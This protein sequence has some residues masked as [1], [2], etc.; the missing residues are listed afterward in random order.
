MCVCVCV[1]VCVCAVRPWTL[2]SAVC[3][4]VQLRC[5]SLSWRMATC[6]LHTSSIHRRRLM[7]AKTV[8][9]SLQEISA[10][11]SQTGLN[12][13]VRVVMRIVH[14]CLQHSRRVFTTFSYGQFVCQRNYQRSGNNLC[15]EGPAS[16]LFARQ[17]SKDFLKRD[18]HLVC[19]ENIIIYRSACNPFLSLQ[20]QLGLKQFITI[21]LIRWK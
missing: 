4:Q 6:L 11:R 19:L 8:L 5:K 15:S 18:F 1:C 17:P 14:V 16:E 2:T 20:C 9:A 3:F 21:K 7:T 12:R 10:L 13:P